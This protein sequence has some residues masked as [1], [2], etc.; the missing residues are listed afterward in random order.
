MSNVI[1]DYNKIYPELEAG[2]GTAFLSDS[3]KSNSLY[4]PKFLS[5]NRAEGRK[6]LSDIMD[7][8][9][10]CI[11]F[12]ISVAFIT[13]NGITP[14]L[15]TLKD[16]E[17]RGVRGRILTTDYLTFSEPKALDKLASFKNIELRLYRSEGTNVGFHT[18]GYYFKQDDI[19]VLIIGSSNLT[20][21]A[22]TTNKEWNTRLIST[23]D[24]ELINTMIQEFDSLWNSERSLKYEDIIDEYRTRFEIIK[25]QR[26]IAKDDEIINLEA[27]RLTPNKM[28]VAF[29]NEIRDLIAR[30]AD[31]GLLISA[32]GT[33]KT[34][35]AAFG[36]RDALKPKKALFVVHREQIAKQARAS[37]KK[38]Y[39]SSKTYGLI[40]GNSKDYDA[41]ITFAT[42]QMMSKKETLEKFGKSE[43]DVIIIDEVHRA[44]AESYRKIMNY[45][46]PKFWLG[47][48]ASPERSDG[49]DIYDLFD[50]NIACEIRLE[51]ALDED[52]LCPFHYFGIT[53]ISVDGEILDEEL[54]L[55]D[56]SALVSDQ[57]ID[58]IIEQAE[59]Y[60]H[61]GDRVKGLVF[62][63]R[64]AEADELSAKF[65][66][67]GYRTVSLGGNDSQDY[68]EE[69]VERL[70]SDS[71]EDA[72][73]YIFTVD[74]FNEGVDLPPI[75]QVIM[76]RPTESPIIFI[77]QLGRGLRKWENKDYVVILDFIG[78]Y[79]NN[80]MITVALSG[81]RSY[82]KDTM[83]RYVSSGARVI[84]GASSIHF[85][86]I[87]Q[88]QIYASIDNA[89][90]NDLKLIRE[91]Y[92][93]LKNK[94]GRIP[95]IKDFELHGEIDIKK[96]FDKMGSYHSFL[97]K[98]EKDYNL[99]LNTSQEAVVKF[100]STKLA[101]GKRSEELEI[102]K[103]L[104]NGKSI[105]TVLDDLTARKRESVFNNL[106]NKFAKNSDQD[107]YKSCVFLEDG[108]RPHRRFMQ[109]LEDYDYREML[110]EI[111]EYGLGEY[112]NKYSSKYKDTDFSLG[113]KYSYEDVC[114][115]LCWDQNQNAQNIGGYFYDRR[116]KT[117]PVFIN[118]EKNDD[119]IK[120]EDRFV[121]PRELIALSKHPRKTTSS[122]ADHIYKRTPDDEN[123]RIFLFV[124]KNKDDKEAKEFYF[125]GEMEAKDNPRGI[126]MPDTKDDA[127]EIDYM[128]ETPVKDELY[129]YLIG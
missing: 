53:E 7:E 89:R 92:Q 98:Y 106:T 13:M 63:S 76:L 127:F 77:Q 115:L 105:D 26:R 58:H 60:G 129:R 69:C 125:L 46:S 70:V 65:N 61:S 50:H 45:F 31:R 111:V 21:N 41:D 74:I 36:L 62:C 84:P 24:G 30:G 102:I 6:V 47:M 1:Y 17:K 78:N 75:N 83:R 112:E 18:K 59:Y 27:Y 82:N 8:L 114:L 44:G 25:E 99:S 40:S 19:D 49:F 71:N 23:K 32:T 79:S 55:R 3:I 14:L 100:V 118:Y 121:T 33:G 96:I 51:Q 94:L 20:A 48:T 64:R 128:L 12:T 80:F 87:A 5:N 15:M 28:Q 11:E 9:S 110:L 103:R 56:F 43:F 86:E 91:S 67:R 37:F 124:R 66:A 120:Y 34:Y 73:D 4:R 95:N 72:L 101:T 85:D 107:K 57:R 2:W 123:N 39:G 97:S 54:A 38:V 35:A 113:E 93:N 88:K 81:D 16:L 122:D 117:L 108:Y 90:T 22:L 42:M 29:I 109:S 10:T 52:L 119:A 104:I 68:R 126:I 116:T